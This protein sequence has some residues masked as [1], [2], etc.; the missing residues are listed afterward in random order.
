MMIK[1]I[2]AIVA[3]FNF[4]IVFGQNVGI[5]TATPQAKL[6]VWNALKATVKIRSNNFNDTTQ[7]ILSNR[8]ATERGTDFNISSNRESGLR[9]TSTSDLPANNHDSIL[10]LTP[11]GNVGINR[12]TPTERLD[13]N[14]NINLK[15]NLKLN[16][17]AG[18]PN[19]LLMTDAAGATAWR[20]MEEFPN[21]KVFTRRNGPTQVFTVPAGITKIFI[22][23][24]GAGGGGSAVG[25]GGGGAYAA[26]I[27]ACTPGD[28][29][30]IALGNGGPPASTETGAATDGTSSGVQRSGFGVMSA[31]GGFGASS[32]ALANPGLGGNNYFFSPAGIL[33]SVYFGGSCGNATKED[34]Q[35]RSSTEFVTTRNYGD[36]GNAA[37]LP[38]TGG[39][40]G[41]KSFNT[42]TLAVIR[43]VAPCGP[44]EP[45]GGG[46]GGPYGTSSWGITGATGMAI[47]HY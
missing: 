40:G 30:D 6:E 7:L 24:W 12:T 15:G 28:L 2:L 22:E 26:A 31:G 27:V 36:G 16:G 25:G 46:A 23:L 47:I 43:T 18:Q 38:N 21:F 37:M 33:S 14:G 29:F 39:T 19:Q 1:A 10:M 17:T 11:N 32:F 8:N 35:Q 45:G 34:Y 4:S 41:F 20:N 42:S 3:G 44:A 5:G 9:I 13:V